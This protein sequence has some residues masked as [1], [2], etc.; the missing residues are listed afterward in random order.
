MIYKVIIKYQYFYGLNKKTN[1]IRKIKYRHSKKSNLKRAA[2]MKHPFVFKA[3]KSVE[4]I[5]YIGQNVKQPTFH[6]IS[7][8]MYFADK[9]HL[10]KYGRFICGDTYVA[11]K[12]GPVPSGIYDILKIVRDNGF[13]PLAEINA[14]KKAFIVDNFLVKPLRFARQD[15]FS[16]SDLEC[17]NN[18]IKQYGILSFNQLTDLSHDRAWQMTDENDYIDIEQIVATL[19]A[20]YLLDYLR[21]PFPE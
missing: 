7:K 1:Q 5:L 12:H 13:A 20:D 17:L 16:E 10:E 11:M 21:D 9:K 2:N 19:D 4:A 14:A 8:I 6:H 3:E 18:A 15:Y